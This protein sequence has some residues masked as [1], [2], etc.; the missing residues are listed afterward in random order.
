MLKGEL[1]I[2]RNRFLLALKNRDYSAIAWTFMSAGFR[3]LGL[4]CAVPTVLILW[5]LKPIFWLKVGVVSSARIGHLGFNTDLFF[6]RRQLGIYP[7][8]PFY[9]FICDPTQL[10]NRQL[11][12]MWKRLIPICESRTLVSVFVGMLPILKRTPFYQD[13]SLNNNE[14]YEFNNAKPSL[15]FT[16]DEI[17]KGSKL[18]T[19][20]GVDLGKNEFVCI[21]ARDD[22]YLKQLAPYNNWSYHNSRN[23]DIDSLIPSA[24]YLIEKGLTVIRIGSVVKKTINFS[25][26]KMIDY[27]FS[28]YRNDFLDIFLLAHCKFLIS[29]GVSGVCN[30]A[31]VFDTPLLAVNTAETGYIP[32]GK[33]CLYLP[34]KYKYINRNDYLHFEEAQNLEKDW[35]THPARFGLEEVG[36]NP[37]GILEATE[38]MLARVEGKFRY[39]PESERL[40]QAYHKL[41][42]ES[43]FYGSPIKTP[44]GIA[45]LKKNQALYF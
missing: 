27:P 11:L 18:L 3:F 19:K 35:W 29:A 41:W 10:A 24:K 8:G 40:I 23:S 26:K 5:I 17:E 6:R 21:F 25:H 36:G 1:I 30:I 16:L 7:D 38:E 4:L 42:E 43:G 31:N 9:C 33:N 22:A 28:G 12:T 13:L 14:Y 44:I 39:S 20:M 2:I 32:I 45:W 34:K 15:Y 37:Q